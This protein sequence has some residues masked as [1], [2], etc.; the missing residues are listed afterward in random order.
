MM[1]VPP[2]GQPMSSAPAEESG[3]GATADPEPQDAESFD[4]P[5]PADSDPSDSEQ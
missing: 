5:E 4:G 3:H 2:G 1:G